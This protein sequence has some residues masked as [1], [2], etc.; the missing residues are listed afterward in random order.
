MIGPLFEDRGENF[1]GGHHLIIS[2]KQSIISAHAI[3]N[4]PLISL[5]RGGSKVGTITEI[6]FDRLYG[7]IDPWNFTVHFE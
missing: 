7:A 6:H 1:P 5:W 2:G 3:A 4:E